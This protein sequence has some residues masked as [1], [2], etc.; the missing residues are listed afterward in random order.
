MISSY[1][2]STF[3]IQKLILIYQEKLH[4]SNSSKDLKP[5]KW[6]SFLPEPNF[7]F[8]TDL[9]TAKRNFFRSTLSGLIEECEIISSSSIG[10]MTMNI[11]YSTNEKPPLIVMDFQ[12]PTWWDSG[13]EHLVAC[14]SGIRSKTPS[15]QVA[16]VQGF[17]PWMRVLETLVIAISLHPY[18]LVRRKM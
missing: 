6:S 12:L 2:S 3:H 15:R 5:V 10:H 7:L 4:Y 9:I 14:P 16:G 17:E 8:S 18:V 13:R 11:F 1:K